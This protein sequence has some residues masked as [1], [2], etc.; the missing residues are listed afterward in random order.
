MYYYNIYVLGLHL[1]RSVY[2]ASIISYIII[3]GN[4]IQQIV[5][6]LLI[7]YINNNETLYLIRAN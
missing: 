4:I 7:F 6:S 2:Y 3:I 5:S 1:F